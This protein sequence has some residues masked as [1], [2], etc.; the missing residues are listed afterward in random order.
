MALLVVVISAVFSGAI[1][2]AVGGLMGLMTSGNLPIAVGLMTGIPIFIITMAIP[3]GF[4]DGLRETY[5][6]STWTLTYREARAL[7]SLDLELEADEPPPELDD[8]ALA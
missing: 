2:L 4:L 7:E 6:S 5:I 3:L 8:P 1:G